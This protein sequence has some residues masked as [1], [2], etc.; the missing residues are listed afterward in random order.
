MRRIFGLCV[1]I[2]VLLA[3]AVAQ[4]QPSRMCASWIAMMV[5]RGLIS[6]E[7]EFDLPSGC[8]ETA[9][10]QEAMLEK[11]IANAYTRDDVK[12]VARA[13]LERIKPEAAKE[14]APYEKLRA[15]KARV[16][17]LFLEKAAPRLRRF[18]NCKRCDPLKLFEAYKL[19][20]EMCSESESIRELEADIRRERRRGRRYG[21][22]RTSEIYDLVDRIDMHRDQ[23]RSDQRQIRDLIGKPFA[24]RKCRKING[25]L[26]GVTVNAGPPP[27]DPD[28]P[29]TSTAS[30]ISLD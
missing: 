24:M 21:V 20:G 5:S 3:A 4:A 12:V 18:M 17:K 7:T 19:A 11:I 26:K 25:L 13:V 15:Y 30:R 27:P 8:G 2:A 14:R 10:A 29:K 16:I 23:L 22:I 28:A 1:C 9:T 6:A